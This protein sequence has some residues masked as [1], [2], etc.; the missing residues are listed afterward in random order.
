MRH[1]RNDDKLFLA[2]IDGNTCEG[3]LRRMRCCRAFPR[4]G[5]MLA[6][7]FG[8]EGKQRLA[9]A[10]GHTA[11]FREVNTLNGLSETGLLKYSLVAVYYVAEHLDEGELPWLIHHINDLLLAGGSLMAVV[12]LQ[13]GGATLEALKEE[14]RHQGFRE[15]ET[16]LWEDEPM[17]SW[18]RLA[19]RG[20][21]LSP[22]ARR[23]PMLRRLRV[24][25]ASVLFEMV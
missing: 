5:R 24:K 15:V 23:I 12:S 16:E 19:N 20:R 18:D 11:P 9:N 10:L 7:A 8:Y 25:T 22:L 13:D 4:E 14:C 1:E 6:V 3:Y 21:P 2:D 17:N